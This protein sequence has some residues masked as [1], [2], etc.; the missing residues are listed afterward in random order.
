[1]DNDR[2]EG[3]ARRRRPKRGR[4]ASPML[5]PS[6]E[7]PFIAEI[8]A[9]PIRRDHTT[10]IASGD[11]RYEQQVSW[12][13]FD[14][15]LQ[16]QNEIRHETNPAAVMEILNIMDS[17][18]PAG[19]GNTVDDALIREIEYKRMRRSMSA[20]PIQLTVGPPVTPSVTT[21]KSLVPMP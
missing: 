14:E 8:F 9:E 16:I 4:E 7:G 21:S 17:P 1:M 18:V 3:W 15:A 11:D 20:L 12:Y 6:P 19:R 10:I 13:K 5:S 2:G